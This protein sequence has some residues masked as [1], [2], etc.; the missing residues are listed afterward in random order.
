MKTN[1]LDNYPFKGHDWGEL[2]RAWNLYLPKDFFFPDPD[3]IYG[4]HPTC[5]D[6]DPIKWYL[7]SVIER[8][9]WCSFNRPMHKCAKDLRVFLARL[10][11]PEKSNTYK[12]E[13]WLGM[14][15][16]ED[17]WTLINFSYQLIH[18]MWD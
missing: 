14:S 15:K 5:N 12:H 9:G 17:D 3:D 6:V 4:F 18:E 2:M 10:G 7:L 8:Y 11:D 1:K 13:M 16:I